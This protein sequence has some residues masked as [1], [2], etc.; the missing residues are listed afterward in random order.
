MEV[1]IRI[2]VTFNN[3]PKGTYSHQF[4]LLIFMSTPS[5][6]S[7]SRSPASHRGGPGSSPGQVMWDLMV[8]KVALGQVFS[9]YFGFSCQF[10]FHRLLHTSSSII[11]DWSNRPNSGRRIKWTKSHTHP[12]K[13]KT[14]KKFLS[15]NRH[16]IMKAA[17]FS[18]CLFSVHQ[19]RQHSRGNPCGSVRQLK[20]CFGSNPSQIITCCA[21]VTGMV[22]TIRPLLGY[23]GKFTLSNDIYIYDIKAVPQLVEALCCKPE[24]RGLYPRE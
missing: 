8:D 19:I 13:L 1:E 23:R 12:K 9:E 4:L 24:G 11:T 17:Y 16:V 10:L 22:N 2:T 15:R 20:T 6:N 14:K 18:P 21:T 3:L 7:G 5:H